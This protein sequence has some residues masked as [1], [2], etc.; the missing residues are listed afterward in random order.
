[1]ATMKD[2]AFVAEAKKRNLDLAPL[3][4]EGVQ[5]VYNTMIDAPEEVVIRM[6]KVLGYN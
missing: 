1:M 4:G 3:D 5:Q 2:P 6:K